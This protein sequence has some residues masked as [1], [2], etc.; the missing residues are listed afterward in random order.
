MRYHNLTLSIVLPAFLALWSLISHRPLSAPPQADRA[1]EVL[2]QARE[3]LGGEAKL[4]AIQS[5]SAAAKYRRVIQ[6][7]E[8]SGEIEVELLLP[9]KYM[10]SETMSVM[11][12]EITRIEALSGDKAWM[13]SRS[14]GGMVVVR[15]SPPNATTEQAE[16]ALRRNTRAE[17]AR[18]LLSFLLTAPASVPI[19]L[20]YLGEAE[21]PDG[22]AHVIEA[23]G[24]DNFA[25]RLFLDQKTHLPLMLSYRGALPRMTMNMTPMGAHGAA[26]SAAEIERMRKEA[27]EKAA[28][29]APSTPQ[30]QQAEIQ[31][32]FSEYRNVGGISFPHRITKAADGQV[33]EEWEMTKFKLNPPLKPG[34]FEKK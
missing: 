18:L 25:A 8:M 31:W 24:A 28:K 32:R 33:N 19:E 23:K 6:E 16:A 1:Q 3:A 20:S 17:F 21:A 29:E 5:L 9:D 15:A 27:Q 34:N 22:R 12:A 2:K 13:D 11:G 30:P 4:K 7:R 10:K 26:P 14:G